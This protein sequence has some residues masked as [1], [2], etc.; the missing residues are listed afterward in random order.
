MPFA[1]ASFLPED[2]I[3]VLDEPAQLEPY[4]ER[5]LEAITKSLTRARAERGEVLPPPAPQYWGEL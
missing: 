5:E 1:T 4:A 2:A 3:L